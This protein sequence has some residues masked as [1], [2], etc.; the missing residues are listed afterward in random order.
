MLNLGQPI[1]GL[2]VIIR[3]EAPIHILALGVAPVIT[4]DDTIGVDHW[5]DP[6][7]KMLSQL[8]G[9]NI[10]GEQKIYQAMNNEATV[11]FSRVLT[12]QYHNCRLE[13]IFLFILIRDFD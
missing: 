3:E 6:K 4:R 12:T 13:R 2:G 5:Q 1:L 7:L 11:R 10:P 9:Q 8:V